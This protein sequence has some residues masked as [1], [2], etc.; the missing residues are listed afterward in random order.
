MEALDAISRIEQ[1]LALSRRD[2]DSLRLDYEGR[3]SSC[4]Q[5]FVSNGELDATITSLRNNLHQVKQDLHRYRK[6]SAESQNLADRLQ[7]EKTNE[8]E[9][10]DLRSSSNL[11]EI[12]ELK[13]SVRELGE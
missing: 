10:F 9:E 5:A 7:Q 12:S 4:E 8:R 3:T 1:E 2:C 13:D 11:K 6:Q